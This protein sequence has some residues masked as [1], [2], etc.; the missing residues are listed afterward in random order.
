MSFELF[1][2][3]AFAESM[4][5]AR[6]S[7]MLLNLIPEFAHRG[8]AKREAFINSFEEVLIQ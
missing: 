8:K 2:F 6:A 3:Y 5:I 4:T 7:D 1:S